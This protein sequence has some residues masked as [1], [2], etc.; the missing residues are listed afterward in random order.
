MEKGKMKGL[1]LEILKKQDTVFSDV[2]WHH[3]LDTLTVTTIDKQKFM[4]GIDYLNNGEDIIR[5][6][7]RSNPFSLYIEIAL[8][9]MLDLEIIT[10]EEYKKYQAETIKNANIINKRHRKSVV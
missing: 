8:L 10:E 9:E 1:L 5:L 2:S 4:I 7:H 3:A 6:W